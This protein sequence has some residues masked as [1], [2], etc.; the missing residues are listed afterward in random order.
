MTSQPGLLATPP[1]TSA[2]SMAPR[3]AWGLF[4]FSLLFSLAGLGLL[5]LTW[6]TP[7]GE[8]WGFRGFPALFSLAFAT[9]GALIAFR[10]PRHPIGWM[11]CVCG[12]LSGVQVFLEEDRKSTR[13]H[14]SH[15]VISYAGFS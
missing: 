7:V 10:Q 13:L 12:V 11:F 5:A 8:R 3:L 14:S 4:G 9:V 15:L 1:A 6:D 2:S